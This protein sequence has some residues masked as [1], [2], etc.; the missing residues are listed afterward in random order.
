MGKFL[1]AMTRLKTDVAEFSYPLDQRGQAWCH[2]RLFSLIVD[3]RWKKML[4]HPWQLN[5]HID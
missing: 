1:S 5:M 4:V 2:L 3:E